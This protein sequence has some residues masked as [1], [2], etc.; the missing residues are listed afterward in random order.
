MVNSIK[1]A[2]TLVEFLPCLGVRFH[3][4]EKINLLLQTLLIVNTG[5][6]ENPQFYLGYFGNICSSLRPVTSHPPTTGWS[7]VR[8]EVS[9]REDEDDLP[10]CKGT[11]VPRNPRFYLDPSVNYKIL[12]TVPFFWDLSKYLVSQKEDLFFPNYFLFW[13]VKNPYTDD[14]SKSGQRFQ[15]KVTIFNL[16]LNIFVLLPKPILYVNSR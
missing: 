5:V 13:E 10:D 11:Q 16:L 6:K 15:R 14:L 9:S 12:P 3:S 2:L 1:E 4:I 8:T 7:D